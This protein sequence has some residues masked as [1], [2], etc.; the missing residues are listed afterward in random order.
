MRNNLNGKEVRDISLAFLMIC[1]I[2]FV[3]FLMLGGMKL[4]M[5]EYYQN[6]CDEMNGTLIFYS[7]CQTIPFTN[8]SD[9]EKEGGVY[10]KLN[11]GTEVDIT[12]RNFTP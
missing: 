7:D 9:C 8:V 1:L 2:V 5:E 4:Q 10:C 11:N 12:I 6:T 3:F